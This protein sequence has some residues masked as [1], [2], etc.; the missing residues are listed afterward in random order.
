MEEVTKLPKGITT[1]R[2]LPGKY[3]AQFWDVCT[4]QAKHIKVCDTVEDAIRA[5]QEFITNLIDTGE[6][7]Q[8]LEKQLPKGIKYRFNNKGGSYYTQV[9]F[10]Y[11]KNKMRHFVA[12]V[13][14]YSTLEEAV[15]ARIDFLDNL[16]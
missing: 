8:P 3:I 14:T 7:V 15:Q 4:H 10:W 5:R 1:N 11:G 12:H 9:Q 6:R 16:K 13:G 2:R